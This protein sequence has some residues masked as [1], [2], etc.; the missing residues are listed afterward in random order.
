MGPPKDPEPTPVKMASTGMILE[1]VYAKPPAPAVSKAAPAGTSGL[2]TS[3]SPAVT[4]TDHLVAPADMHKSSLPLAYHANSSFNAAPTSAVDTHGGGALYSDQ[5]DSQ[6]QQLVASQA[7][8]PAPA[9][10]ATMDST[11]SSYSSNLPSGATT[12]TTVTTTVLINRTTSSSSTTSRVVGSMDADSGLAGVS[13]P[14]PAAT[15]PPATPALQA[16]SPAATTAAPTGSNVSQAASAADTKDRA[17]G[18]LTGSQ[19]QQVSSPAARATLL[20]SQSSADGSAAGN[21]MQPTMQPRVETSPKASGNA[22]AVAGRP[23]QIASNNSAAGNAAKAAVE[24]TA[25]VSNGS[26][27]SSSNTAMLPQQGQPAVMAP[28][29]TSTGITGSGAR[30][31][32]APRTVLPYTSAFSNVTAPAPFIFKQKGAIKT[33]MIGC[34]LPFEGSQQLAGEAVYSALKLAITD[35]APKIIPNLNINLT[36]FNSRCSDIPTYAAVTRLAD[37]GA[38]E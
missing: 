15:L 17:A 22:G 33:I 4:A 37:E 6:A 21:N 7:D 31:T 29:H 12:T 24:V 9:G 2:D 19:Q 5:I 26:S 18:P 30:A 3:G 27:N 34:S 28:N 38:S 1:P 11:T 14:L 16:D 10:V 36:C 20:T 8:T 35:L 23:G 25:T 13:T 32:T